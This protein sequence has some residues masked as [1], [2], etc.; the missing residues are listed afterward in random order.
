MLLPDA[1]IAA[2]F[3]LQND[4]YKSKLKIVGVPFTDEYYGVAVK[5]GNQEILD[6]VNAGLKKVIDSGKAKELEDKWLR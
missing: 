5:K 2:D 4:E 3:V 1:P 6:L